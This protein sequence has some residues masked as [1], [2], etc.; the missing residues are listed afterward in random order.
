MD[1]VNVVFQDSQQIGIGF[2]VRDS[3][4]SFV[5]ARWEAI[6][7]SIINPSL[8]EAMSFEALSWIK[9][10]EF[11][12]III[13]SDALNLVNA[14]KN[15]LI[16]LIYGGLVILDCIYIVNEITRCIISYMRRSIN[17]SF[18][19]ESYIFLFDLGV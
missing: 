13:E 8:A 7:S 16:A 18:T 15:R 10:I 17:S 3:S 2:V 6:S 14:I 1:G 12:P 4:G 5:A 19:C 11:S 9:F